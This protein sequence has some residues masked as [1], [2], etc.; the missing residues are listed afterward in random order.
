MPMKQRQLGANG[1]RV[2]AIGLGCLGLTLDHGT[3]EGIEALATLD[4]A[5]ELGIDFFDTA[6][7]YGDGKSEQ[8]L[9]T[10]FRDRRER[11]FIA[12]KFG[13]L[14]GGGSDRKIDGRPEYVP[15]ACESSLKRLG[16]DAIDLYYLHRVD[17]EVPI[18][19][20]VGAMQ[21][22]VQQGKVRYLGLSE[23]SPS[24]IRRAHAIHPITALQNE[25]S[26]WSRDPEGEVMDTCRELGIALVPYS[27][28]GRGFLT[29]SIKEESALPA[30]DRRRQNPRFQSENLK[31]NLATLTPLENVARRLSATPAQVSLAW[32]LAQGDDVVPIPGTR[33]RRYLESNA[34][35]VDLS[36]TAADV[37]TLSQAFPRGVAV[38]DR[39]NRDAMQ[40]M[41][42]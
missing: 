41:N 34:G 20:T 28:L 21:K 31:R 27:P 33:H 25:Y 5:L 7:G 29:G 37:T 26:L 1:P 40:F 15:K 9:G 6:D 30:N 3:P 36:L 35:A 11:I 13:N 32:V 42:G 22:L 18:E 24:T 16:I 38:G 4:R 12:T 8:F 10:A 17:P 23:A 2:S 14:R 19:D 39:H